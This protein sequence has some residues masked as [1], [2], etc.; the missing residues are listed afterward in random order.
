MQEVGRILKKGLVMD[1]KIYERGWME[2]RLGGKSGEGKREMGYVQLG[3]GRPD[4]GLKG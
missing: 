1:L 4:G 3:S 2:E